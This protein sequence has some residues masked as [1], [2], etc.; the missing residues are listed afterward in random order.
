MISETKQCQNCKQDFIIEPD[1]F[2][3]YEKMGVPVPVWCIDCRLQR[4]F[5]FRNERILYKRKCNAPGHDEDIISIYSPDKKIKVYDHNFWWGDDWDPMEYGMD[6]D[7]SISFMKQFGELMHNVPAQA[8]LNFNAVNSEYCNYTTDNKNCYLVFG[9]DF[10]ENCSYSTFNMRSKDSMDMYW[11]DHCELS[12]EV[13]DCGSCYKVTHSRYVGVCNDCMFMYQCEGCSNCFGC[14]NLKK[15]SYCIFNE[16]YT[17]EEYEKK[18]KEIAPHRY[19]NL[20]KIK[21]QFNELKLSQPHRYAQIL[22]AVNS[23][24]E[25]LIEVKDCKKCFDVVGPA[26]NMKDVFLAGWGAKDARGCDHFGHGS[27]LAHDSFTVFSGDSNVI[28]SYLISSSQN[29][30]YSYNCRGCNNIFGCV[31]LKSKSYCIFNKQYSKEEYEKLVP[32]IK[33]H[34]NDVP[35]IDSKGKEY[36]YGEFFSPEI[37]LF[38]YNETTAQEYFRLEKDVALEA[39]YIWHEEEEKK[40][41][42]TVSYNDLPDTIE[43]VR[44]DIVKEIILCKHEGKCDEGCTK[45]F[46]ITSQELQFY[47]RLNLPLPRFCSSC[48]Y[49]QRLRSRP[50]LKLWKRVCQCAGIESDNGVYPN[51]ASSHQSHSKEQH[52]TN[53]F[54]TT[55]SPD[56]KEI[57]YCEQCFQAE[58]A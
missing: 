41:E 27:E 21:K 6:L 25:N 3:F 10:N 32:E 15:K 30:Q 9:G 7:F 48:R 22:K 23:S 26:E 51:N 40:Y 45:A 28:C 58:V 20:E 18:M 52:C 12:Y 38:G 53:E 39:G 49:T 5:S 36:K 35:Y 19:S 16:Q 11:T 42:S 33:Q 31:G 47:R 17:K 54:E 55:Y 50:P 44:D 24:G 8:L 4:R 37:S 2:A 56:R 14:V 1:D 29:V 57:V 13:V 34:M 46:R 43:E